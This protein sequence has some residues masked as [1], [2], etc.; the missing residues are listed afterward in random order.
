M[1]A[2][3]LGR[4]A[5]LA[6][7]ALAS[8]CYTF[9]PTR[10]E[11]ARPQQAVRVRLAPAEAARLADFADPSTRSLEGKLVEATGDSLLL[12]VPSLTE[13]RGTR[14]ETLHQRVQ[15]GRAGILDME[16]RNLDRPRTWLVSGLAFA[17]VVAI[18][19]DQLSGN[20]GSEVVPPGGGPNDAVLPSVRIPIRVG[21]PLFR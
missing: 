17:A 16:V 9:A 3:A 20:G 2:R 8:G 7:L 6:L 14:V 12:L 18:A 15:V 4:G 10:P 1:K 11:E 21:W 5:V 19:V 13:L